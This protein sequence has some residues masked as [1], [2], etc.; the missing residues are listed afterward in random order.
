VHLPGAGNAAVKTSAAALLVALVAACPLV[1]AEEPFVIETISETGPSWT[2][3]TWGYT[4]PKLLY[5]GSRTYAVGLIGP[6]SGHS[7]IQVYWRDGAG[8]YAGAKLEPVY[9][10]STLLLDGAGHT[11]VFC[12]SAGIRAYHWRS[13]KPHD[14]TAFTEVPLPQPELFRFGYLGVGTD[15]K[16]LALAGLDGGYNLWLAVKPSLDAPWGEAHQI[17][18]GKTGDPTGNVGPC[19]PV[20]MPAGDQVHLVYSVSPDGSVHNTYNK[21][22]YACF[23]TRQQKVTRQHTIA[24]STPG[25][26]TYGLD[27]LRGPDGTLYSLYF[28]HVYVYGAKP[29]GEDALRGLYLAVLRPGGQWRAAKVT[30]STGTAQLFHSPDGTLHVLESTSAGTRD[31]ASTDGGRSF[32]AAVHAWPGAGG[33]L[34]VVKASSGSVV[35]GVVRGAQSEFPGGGAGSRLQ[36]VKYDPRG[37]TAPER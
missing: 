9:Q 12:T 11:N 37:G 27:A 32:G 19:Y 4:S 20:V 34:Y 30:D 2:G 3:H 28:G 22:V 14:V 7:H 25:V 24:R 36:Y 21:V 10:P 13:D 17:A 23:D 16:Q 8:W 26:M 35:D 1:R 15:G 29:E 5:D 33:F 31:Y 6:D 18:T